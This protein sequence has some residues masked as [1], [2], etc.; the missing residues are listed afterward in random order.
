MEPIELTPAGMS[1][2]EGVARVNRAVAA[3]ARAVA[4]AADALRDLLTALEG[5]EFRHPATRLAKR[6]ALRAHAHRR[7]SD[8]EFLR[9]LAGHPP[10]S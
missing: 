3:Q 7:A 9:A 1:T 5:V 8:E 6:E 4:D 10:R 2:P